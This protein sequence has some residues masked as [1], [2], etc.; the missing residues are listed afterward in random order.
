[1]SVCR[2]SLFAE[3]LVGDF[4]RCSCREHGVCKNEGLTIKIGAACVFDVDVEVFTLV[5]FPVRCDKCVL[6]SVEEVE[7]TL[8]QWKSRAKNGRN[9]NLVVMCVYV[10]NAERCHE[11][12]L[13]IFERLTDFVCEDLA[14]SFKVP[15]ESQTILLDSY[16]AHFRYEFVE[17][18]VLLAK[19]DDFHG[20]NHFCLSAQI[21]LFISTG[22]NIST[23]CSSAKL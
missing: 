2:L 8:V 11:L 9:H 1:M 3:T 19:V 17:N 15:A 5:V 10:C 18:R 4:E 20:N 13:G 7:Y 23:F 21:Y 16:V 6:C 12:L 14:E 22:Q